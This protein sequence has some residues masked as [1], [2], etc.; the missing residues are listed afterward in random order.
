MPTINLNLS[1]S[2]IDNAIKELKQ[3]QDKVKSAPEKITE[4]LAKEA[5]QDIDNTLSGITDTD[6]NAI[7]EIGYEK[8]GNKTVVYNRGPQ[9]AFLEFGTGATGK[10][11]PHP[12]AGQSGWAYDV[13]KKIK[14][15]K[16]GKR[17]WR[18]YDK[19][20]GHW[21]ITSGMPAQMQ[22]FK[23]A[24]KMRNRVKQVAKEVLLE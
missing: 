6:G 2:S 18:Y 13:G 1:T 15:S 17:Q 19:I 8:V 11:S 12:Q 7:G 10:S 9:I 21:R 14:V 5:V 24:V 23:A 16:N 20:K 22:V 3:Y 4:R